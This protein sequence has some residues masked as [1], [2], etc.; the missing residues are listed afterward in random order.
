MKDG[1]ASAGIS[2]AAPNDPSALRSVPPGIIYHTVSNLRIL[3]DP[4]I[5]GLVRSR[6]SVSGWPTDVPPPGLFILTF[7]GSQAVRQWAKSF[8]AACSE[9]P[10]AED[11]FVTGHEVALRTVFNLI[12]KTANHHNSNGLHTLSAEGETFPVGTLSFTS[13]PNEIWSGFCQVLRQIPTQTIL[14]SY[15]G[16]DCRRV[17][18][19]HLHDTGPRMCVRFSR[20]H[21]RLRYLLVSDF[22]HILKCMLFLLKRLSASLWNGEAPEFPQVVFDAIKDNPSYIKLIEEVAPLD[23]KP[24]FLS[25]FGEYLLSLKDSNVFGDVL[26]RIIDFLCEELQHER[27]KEVRP[28]VM[29]AAIRVSLWLSISG[30]KLMFNDSCFRRWSVKVKLRNSLAIVRQCLASWTFMSMFSYL[31]LLDATTRTKSGSFPVALLVIS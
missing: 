7:D 22:A 1:L 3:R 31:L 21:L 23:E 12:A 14:R 11:H 24:W 18:T 2:G 19:G 15:G 9:I 13:D 4:D 6:P 26:A 17:V 20:M 25:W 8:L 5:L 10:M 29:F 28:V 30:R 16:V 27:F